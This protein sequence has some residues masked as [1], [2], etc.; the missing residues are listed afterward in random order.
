MWVKPPNSPK[1]HTFIG[2]GLKKQNKNK[3][4]QLNFTLGHDQIALK[5]KCLIEAQ[6]L[7]SSP[8]FYQV[9]SNKSN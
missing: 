1:K 2:P 3:C 4:N 5:G 6:N 9:G 7:N 8:K